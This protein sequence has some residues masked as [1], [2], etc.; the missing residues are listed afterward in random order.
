MPNCDFYAAGSDFKLVLDFV[1]TESGCRIFESY[2]P[3]GEQLREFCSYSEIESRYS[4][5]QC[6][7]SASS[8]NLQLLPI[9]AGEVIIE[10]NN[11]E[12]QHC[13]GFTYRF[14]SSGWGL[15]QLYLGGISPN[16]LVHSHTNHNSEKRAFAWETTYRDK[17]GPVS[18][19][20]WPA[21]EKTSRRINSFIRKVSV[22]KHGSRPILP[23]ASVALAESKI[24]T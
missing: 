5:G 21:I 4:I 2:S 17:L 13:N 15:I 7:G 16:G 23:Q 6:R 1:L 8:V 24:C 10:R 11:L 18:A 9:G 14:C 22:A 20:S 19:W 3:Y 12:P